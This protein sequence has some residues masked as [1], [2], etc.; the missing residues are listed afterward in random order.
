MEFFAILALG[1]AGYALYEVHE[2]KKKDPEQKKKA[3]KKEIN[4]HEQLTSLMNQRCEIIV[5][6]AMLLI[7]VAYS[8]QGE[9]ID[10]DDEWVFIAN[11]KGK[12]KIEKILRIALIKD[13]KQIV[14]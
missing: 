13:V 9:I 14:E 11:T 5:K 4:I 10:V 2:L 8:F 7:D 1:L 3:L 6:D 12:K